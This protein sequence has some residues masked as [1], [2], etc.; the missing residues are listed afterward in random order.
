MLY[1][2]VT[3]CTSCLLIVHYNAKISTNQ[4]I[5]LKITYKADQLLVKVWKCLYMN[6][7]V[8]VSP[9]LLSRPPQVLKL[10]HRIL[11]RPSRK[12]G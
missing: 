4:K 10:V 6:F 3:M 7:N 11:G 2:T 5:R 9:H 12:S 1:I 8:T